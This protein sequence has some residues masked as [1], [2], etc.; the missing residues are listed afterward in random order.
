M[1]SFEHNFINPE[2]ILIIKL[3]AMGDV[4]MAE[5]I[6]RCIRQHYRNAHITLM[7]EPLYARFMKKCPHIDAFLPYTRAP[8]WHL[9]ALLD[10]KEKL[11]KGNFDLVIDL[12]NSSRSRQ[13]QSWLK[14]SA[15][16]SSHSKY[17]HKRY[18]PDRARHLAIRDYLREQIEMI[19]VDTSAGVLPNLRWAAASVDHLLEREQIKDGFVL[20]IPGSAARHP[21]KRW[22]GYADLIEELKKQNIVTVTAPGPDELELCASLPAKMLLEN[23]ASLTFN[24]LV[25]LSSHCRWVV[26]NDTGPTHLMAACQTR[27]IGLFGSNNSPAASTGISAVYEVIEKPLIK[28]ITVDDVMA[29]VARLQ[30]NS[31]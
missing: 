21:L 9:G 8:R 26:G 24:Q 7:T 22:R 11:V 19:G 29:A 28:Y 20:L 13:F 31:V 17:A 4:I 1:S 15:G 3:G 6:M 5:G 10:I 12:Q 2:R 14:N 18:I 23:G 27:G 30:S 25:G 16:I